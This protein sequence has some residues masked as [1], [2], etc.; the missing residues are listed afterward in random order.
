MKTRSIP[1]TIDDITNNIKWRNIDIHKY[2]HYPDVIKYD[3][4]V[5]VNY[6]ILAERHMGWNKTEWNYIH[7]VNFTKEEFEMLKIPWKYRKW[8]RYIKW[9]DLLKYLY[10]NL[11]VYILYE[12]EQR[13]RH[14]DVFLLK[15]WAIYF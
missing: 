11:T 7:S 3:L 12:L 4:L 13:G 2:Y 9:E 10:N 14:K 5:W 8:W 1:L 6:R 15:S